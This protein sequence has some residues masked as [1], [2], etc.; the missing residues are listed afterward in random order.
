MKNE[1]EK[2]EGRREKG[3]GRRIRVLCYAYIIKHGNNVFLRQC[4]VAR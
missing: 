3:E 1:R 2:G 4:W